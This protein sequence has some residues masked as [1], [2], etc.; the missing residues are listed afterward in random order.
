M[1]ISTVF[2][3]TFLL[4]NPELRFCALIID[5]K[6]LTTIFW[7][8]LKAFNLLRQL[9]SET[10]EILRGIS[11][12]VCKKNAKANTNSVKL[13]S[14]QSWA[15][16]KIF[17][18]SQKWKWSFQLIC[19]LHYLQ[20]GFQKYRSSRS[21]MYFRIGVLKNFAMFTG[22]YLCLS[23]FFINIQ[24]WKPATLLKKRLRHRC[25]PVKFARFLRTPFFTEHLQWLLQE[26]SHEFSLYCIWEQW[27][28]SFRGTY[29]LSSA[30]FILL[31]VSRFFLFLSFFLFFVDSTSFSF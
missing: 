12:I 29:L 30:Y 21:Q 26:I 31:G 28:V 7:C 8:R 9:E 18:K 23:L 24:A 27:M 25:F 17:C 14:L 15:G 16:K 10:L 13:K 4:N 2:I 11:K 3:S 1:F 22:K 19:K 20:F 5:W 6:L